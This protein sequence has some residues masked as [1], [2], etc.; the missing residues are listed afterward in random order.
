M[1]KMLPTLD[2]SEPV[3]GDLETV[4]S[5][6]DVHNVSACNDCS[7]VSINP[8]MYLFVC[9][10]L[11]AFQKDLGSYQKSVNAAYEI[12]EHLVSEVLDDPA[13]TEQDMKEL[14]E[15]WDNIC[16]QSVKKQE[17]LDEACEAAQAFED[18]FA[19]LVLWVDAQCAELQS[20]PPPDEDATVLQQQIDEHKVCVCV[21]VH[22]HF[23][24]VYTK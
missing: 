12:G 18:S 15:D 9:L 11:Q 22:V 10:C 21:C 7:H 5:L 23:V 13:V 8:Y 17:R 14:K 3:H 19:D 6:V 2:E 16:Q 4:E 24:C 20:Q 1:A